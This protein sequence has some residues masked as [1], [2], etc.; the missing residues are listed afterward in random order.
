[1]PPIPVDER[2]SPQP[3]PSDK[4]KARDFPDPPSPKPSPHL[5]QPS[6]SSTSVDDVLRKAIGPGGFDGLNE[7]VLKILLVRALTNNSSPGSSASSQLKWQQ[8]GKDIQPSLSIDGS[9]FPAWSAAL[10]ELVA[11]VTRREDY[12]NQCLFEEDASTALGV[13]TV[14]K[15]SIDPA[16]RPS[17]HGMTAYG[18]WTSLQDR[19]AG[20]SWSMLLA[21]WIGLA[22]T[23]D[24][25]SDSVAASYESFKRGLLDVEER[26][27]GW[28]T[29]KLLCFVFHAALICYGSEVANAM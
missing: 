21:R 5:P 6:P 28:T 4:G 9:N 18:A 1:M 13:L 11:T 27:G 3:G 14:I 2:R 20:S 17:L 10:R 19:F 26:I 12:F 24:D 22:R 25:A 8:L 7:D 29:D 15:A 23:T 16:L